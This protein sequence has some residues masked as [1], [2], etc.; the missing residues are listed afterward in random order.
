MS[1]DQHDLLEFLYPESRKDSEILEKFKFTKYYYDQ[2][3]TEL[4]RA[5][6]VKNQ[7]AIGEQEI[8]AITIK[9]KEIV[10]KS[11]SDRKSHRWENVRSWITTIIAISGFLLSLYSLY[12]QSKS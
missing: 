7:N 5:G 2:L 11:R 10:E 9:G 8:L 6:A 3:A 12:L 4:R 1:I